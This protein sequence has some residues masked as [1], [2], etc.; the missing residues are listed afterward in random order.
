MLSTNEIMEQNN[1]IFRDVLE[2]DEINLTSE[3]TADDI[4]EWDSLTHIQV[5]VAL[6]KHYKIRFSTSEITSYKNV[7]ELC[8]S[9]QK[10]LSS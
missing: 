9:I 1:N 5:I 10:K 8:E 2:N 7:G 4:E 6:E 3:T